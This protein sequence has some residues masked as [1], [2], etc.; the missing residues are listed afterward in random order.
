MTKRI[1]VGIWGIGRAGWNMHCSELDSFSDMYEVVAAC[2]IDESRLTL[3]QERYPNAKTYLN[4]DEFLADENI[5]LVSIVVPSL[6]HIEYTLKAL[7]T[8]KK[9]FLEKPISLAEADLEQLSGYEGQLYFRHNR[10]FESC[11]NHIKDILATGILGDINEVKLCRHSYMRRDD[12]QTLKEFG[13]GQL[14]N[15]GP[16]LIDHGLYFVNWKIASLWADIRTVAARGTADDTIKVIMK[17]ENNCIVD[18]EISNGVMLPNSVYSIFGSRGSLISVD[19][20]EIQLKY[21]DPNFEL[22]N[23]K[24]KGGSPPWDG[25]YGSLEGIPFIEECIKTA[26]KCGCKMEDIYYYLYKTIRDN[27]PF[28][29]TTQ[30]AFEV[31]K[32]AEKIRKFVEI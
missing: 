5:E 12:W 23:N 14:N 21:I 30:Q 13:G 8:G 29:V 3:F 27:E 31:V 9:V 10:R 11:F 25:G 4:G 7:A 22:P 24:S 28:A 17:G 20:S 6:F 32:T 15:W 26:P 16:H 1:K 18:I 2:D 19:E